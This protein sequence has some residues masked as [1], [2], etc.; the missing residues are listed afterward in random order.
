[1]KAKINEKMICIPPYVSTSW[2][3]VTFMQAEPNV[4]EGLDLVMHL[5][6]GSQITIRDLDKALID[7]AFSAHLKYLEAKAEQQENKA[8]GPSGLLQQLL[9]LPAEQIEGVPFR[10]GLNG[11]PG[12]ENIEM[13]MQHDA[14]QAKAA[15]LPQEL[16]EKVMQVTKMLTGG[17]LAGFPKPEPHCNCPHCQ[18]SRAMHGLPKEAAPTEELIEDKDLTFRDWDIKQIA[19]NLYSVV[20]PLDQDEQYQVFIG[21]P[22]G[23][24]CG[25]SHCEHLKAVLRS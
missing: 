3:H 11:I 17:N 4:A 5:D 15:D 1:M 21:Q 13:A 22:I 8:K 6:N 7:L 23:C 14:S 12:L 18:M 19:D 24:T 25:H 9:G 16:L 10:L 2:D 20:N